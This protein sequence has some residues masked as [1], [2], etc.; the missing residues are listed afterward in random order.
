MMA[1]PQTTNN[2]KG[3]IA[4]CSGVA[5]FAAQDTIIKALSGDYSVTLAIVL[6]SFVSFPVLVALIIY[7]GGLRQ[8]ETPHWRILCARGAIL[9][10]AYITYF[11]A[12]PAL[13]LAEAIALFF[14]VPV[15]I[16]LMAGPMLGEKITL[17]AWAAVAIGLIGVALILQP[18]SAIFNPAAL[19]SLVAAAAYALAMILARK[20]GSDVP[21][22]VMAFY[23]NAV[24][25]VLALALATIFAALNLQP[26]GHPSLDFLLRGWNVP[27]FR[28]MG[29]MGLCGVIAAFGMTL[30]TQ[31]YRVGQ[32]N[33]V[34][35]FEY[36]GMIWGVLWGMALFHETPRLSTLLGMGL[37]AV[38]GILA[39]RGQAT[40]QKVVGKP[41]LKAGPE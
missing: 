31:A 17:M 27:T 5:L 6:R 36:T 25:L 22:S 41:A 39:L 18:G 10:T 40:R 7:Q 37:I 24:Y 15:F 35:P 30:L 28:D 14:M 9:M 32:A 16:T 8:L 33:V 29:L 23:Q 19:L 26:P 3:I 20:H 13:P 12:F 11:I 21:A 4:L 38:A 2:V 1:T 34:T